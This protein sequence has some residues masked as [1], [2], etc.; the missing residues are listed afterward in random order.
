MNH[1]DTA[2]EATCN[3]RIESRELLRYFACSNPK[4]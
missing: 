4:D 3:E 1:P 2:D